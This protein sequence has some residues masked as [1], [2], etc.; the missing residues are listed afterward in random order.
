[1]NDV[2]AQVTVHDVDLTNTVSVQAVLRTIQPDGVFHL[3]ALNSMY[4]V[5]PT[6]EDV[7]RINSLA[8]INLIDIMD[9]F[10]YG[11][12]VNTGTGIETGPQE[13]SVKEDVVCAPTEAYSISKLTATLYAQMK[14]KTKEK[15]IVTIRVFTPYGP[16]MQ[17][18]KIVTQLIEGA[19][20]QKEITL[21]DTKVTRDFIYI[22][23]LIDLYIRA[24][25]QAGENHG[26]IFNGGTGVAT[27]LGTLVQVVE[28]VSEKHIPIVWSNR[29]ACQGLVGQEYVQ[30]SHQDFYREF[31]QSYR[32]LQYWNSVLLRHC[33]YHSLHLC[34]QL[35]QY[36]YRNHS[37]ESIVANALLL[38]G[39]GSSFLQS[40][41]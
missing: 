29:I 5:V 6:T 4:G 37:R 8:T 39:V 22:D 7:F 40:Y 19:L 26:E 17:K 10:D 1:M 23:D 3:A 27:D 24:A 25:E 36:P 30:Y 34:A 31:L 14:G 21:S 33:I 35:Y 9:E 13:G 15:P 41:W 20:E 32:A 12:F 2:L 38:H 11:F 28:A 16:F 18:G